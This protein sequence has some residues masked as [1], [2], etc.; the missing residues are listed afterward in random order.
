MLPAPMNELM[1]ES[2]KQIRLLRTRVL[3][4]P[5]LNGAGRQIA[6]SRLDLWDR[7]VKEGF[8]HV[9][10]DGLFRTEFQESLRL[11]LT[12]SERAISELNAKAIP[13]L[14]LERLLDLQEILVANMDGD[15]SNPSEVVATDL[16][17]AIQSQVAL[18][19]QLGSIFTEA[20]QSRARIVQLEGEIGTARDFMR[21]AVEQANNARDEAKRAAGEA[22]VS[23]LEASF[24]DYAKKELLASFVFRLATLIVLL[25]VGAFAVVF[26]ILPHA[27]G[28]LTSEV[29]YRIAILTA[30]GALSA[31]LAR[32]AT[33]HRRNG[34]WAQAIEVQLKSFRAFVD[35][36]PEGPSKEAMYDIFGRRVLGSPPDTRS[37]SNDD[38]NLLMAPLM[39]KMLR[40]QAE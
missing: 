22:G 9:D 6:A 13:A 4:S 8:P 18:E 39:E 24:K 17:I 12:V 7:M 40:R 23:A 21:E 35:P 15:V 29:V 38:L 36:I 28:G 16:R 11:L 34:D 1:R 10:P 20:E 33:H 37:A 25:G 3:D 30:F 5:D 32:Q 26:L 14:L 2:E 31:Y 27:S 19:E